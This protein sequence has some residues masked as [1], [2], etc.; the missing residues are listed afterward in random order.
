MCLLRLELR[1][2]D[3]LDSYLARSNAAWSEELVR[4]VRVGG[5]RSRVIEDEAV[6][7]GTIWDCH[8]AQIVSRDVRKQS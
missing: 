3:W 2:K 6:T 5:W 7:K 8:R 1:I 4:S